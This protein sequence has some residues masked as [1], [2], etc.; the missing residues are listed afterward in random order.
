MKTR[1]N[2]QIQVRPNIGIQ[3]VI[4]VQQQ[5]IIIPTERYEYNLSL[6]SIITIYP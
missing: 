3:P 5:A 2:A 1:V 4:R 6:K